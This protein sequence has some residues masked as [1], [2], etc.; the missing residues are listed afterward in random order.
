MKLCGGKRSE[1]GEFGVVVHPS[2]RWRRTRRRR[3]ASTSFGVPISPAAR[4]RASSLARV[5]GRRGVGGRR[6]RGPRAVPSLRWESGVGRAA[7]G[8]G[9]GC[10][11]DVVCVRAR[12]VR[13]IDGRPR[14]DAWL[15]ALRPT[16]LETRTKELCVRASRWAHEPQWRSESDRRDPATRRRRN[17]GP[18]LTRREW[19]R[20]KSPY[21]QTR[22]VVNYA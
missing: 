5:I 4:W 13:R 21:A 15:P 9:G 22:K 16:R 10:T 3:S 8:R 2:P 6:G 20:R 7:L 1:L 18:S 19:R 17:V 11:A 14:S 12:Q